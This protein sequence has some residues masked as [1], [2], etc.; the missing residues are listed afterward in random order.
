[1][2]VLF[3]NKGHHGAR[4]PYIHSP[5]FT[6]YKMIVLFHIP[7]NR[8]SFILNKIVSY[9]YLPNQD[10]IV[11]KFPP[12][13]HAKWQGLHL[14]IKINIFVGMDEHQ[15]QSIQTVYNISWTKKPYYQ[16]EKRCVPLQS[17]N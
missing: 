10:C 8:T 3:E 9:L 17:K 2:I 13:L 12:R 14:S 4:D 5:S 11:N 1:M 6:S 16:F 7:V 15:H